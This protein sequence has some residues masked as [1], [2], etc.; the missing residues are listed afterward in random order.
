MLNSHF[1]EWEATETICWRRV[2]EYSIPGSMRGLGKIVF[3]NF[4]DSFNLCFLA[5]LAFEN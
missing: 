5:F 2:F 3:S 4:L 1:L